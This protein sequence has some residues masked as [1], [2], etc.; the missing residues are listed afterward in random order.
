MKKILV[1]AVVS[2][3]WLQTSAYAAW[4]SGVIK[5]VDSANRVVTIERAG[6]ELQE[7][8]PKEI[9]VKVLE[10]ARLKNMTTLDE[11]QT[12]QEVKV[13]ARANKEQGFWDANYIELI[14]ADADSKAEMEGT[15]APENENLPSDEGQANQ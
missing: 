8:Y 13:D 1:L 7:A 12:G 15:S 6:A 4:M 14:D 9:Q 10:N 2:F 11:L 5:E 3:L